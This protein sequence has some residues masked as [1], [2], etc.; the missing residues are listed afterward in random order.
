MIHSP[1]YDATTENKHFSWENSETMAI[2]DTYVKLPEGIMIDTPSLVGSF[3]VFF[4][5][6][7]SPCNEKNEEIGTISK[8][9][10]IW[11]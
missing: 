5:R 1:V 3:A 4:F 11:G 2:L 8:Y 7:F 6:I 9:T 10:L